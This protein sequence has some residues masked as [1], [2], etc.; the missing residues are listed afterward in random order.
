MPLSTI[1]TISS[2]IFGKIDSL[3][4][5]ITRRCSRFFVLATFGSFIVYVTSIL[6]PAACMS[7]IS[8]F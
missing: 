5:I 6:A 1:N 4:A 2:P 3:H 7:Q 8:S